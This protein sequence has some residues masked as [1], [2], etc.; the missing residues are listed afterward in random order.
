VKKQNNDGLRIIIEQTL[1]KIPELGIWQKRFMQILFLSLLTLRGRVNFSNLARHSELNEKTYRRGFEKD[2]NFE[3]F[4]LAIKEERP[5]KG[6][7]VAAI[8]TSYLPKAGKK[9]F[10]LGKFYSS[11]LNKAVKGL[12]ISEIALIDRG[13]QQAYAFSTRQT[14]EQDGKRRLELYIEHLELSASKLP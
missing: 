12:E 13:S 2:F 14:V 8:D 10:G 4:N 9:T 5:V 11:C 7:L 3:N 1:G 6:E